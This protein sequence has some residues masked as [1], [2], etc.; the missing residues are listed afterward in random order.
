VNAP[1][2]T[3]IAQAAHITTVRASS[4]GG[5]F[6]CG[7]K[8]EGEHLLDMR[9]PSGLRAQ[10]GTAIH[11]STAKF[12]AGRLP[13]GDRLDVNECAGLFVDTLR[14]PERDVDYTQ[15]DLTV[16][17]AEKIGLQL[18]T[19][20]CLD[21]SPQFTFTSVEQALTP[22]DIDCGGG[23]L[24]RLTGSMDRARVAQSEDGVVIPDLKSG[25]RV[26][27]K[28]EAQIKGRSAQVGT[29]QLLYEHTEAVQTIGGQVL[30]L[31][32]SGKPAVAASK[33]FDAKRVMVGTETQ[34]GL[35]QFA[36]EMFR[37]GLFPPN[38]QSLLCSTKY[39]ARWDTCN[40]HE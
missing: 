29:Y 19:L 13:G 2:R 23:H 35:I 17:E 32:T 28:G 38:P 33:V 36:A 11:A 22:L 16:T 39:C 18:H 5:L 3:A 6:D 40:F 7:H 30:A 4:W 26:I 9:K 20:Y 15:D 10:L 21:L 37:T 14:N 34:P 27:A 31:Q 25:S 8:W 12:D 24:I 1:D